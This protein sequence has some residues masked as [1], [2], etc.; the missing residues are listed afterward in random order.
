MIHC[1]SSGTPQLLRSGECVMLSE[2]CYA[3]VL[4]V[5]AIFCLAVLFCIILS[6]QEITMGEGLTAVEAGKR[7]HCFPLV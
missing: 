5:E 6:V 4:H 2:P 1:S 7:V 3:E